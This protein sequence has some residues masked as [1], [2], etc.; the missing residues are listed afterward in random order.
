[1]THTKLNYRDLESKAGLYFLREPLE[2]E[3]LGLSVIDV[4]DGRDGF[5][6]DHA[7][8]GEEEIYLLLE[9]SATMTVED[10]TTALEPG[11]AIRIDP[12]ATR[13]VDLE[14]DATMVVAGA[15]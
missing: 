2:A 12:E 13:K 9:G 3:E 5:E 15:P 10:E 4:D 11:D 8:D 7:E 6:H 14:G 1:M